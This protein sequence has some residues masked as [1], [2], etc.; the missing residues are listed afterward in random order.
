MRRHLALLFACSPLLAQ[1]LLAQTPEPSTQ[2]PQDPPSES[3][4]LT[5]QEFA[6]LHQ[7]KA[8]E[9]PK[10][11]GTMVKIAG[12]Q[13]YLALPK[14]QQAPMPAVLVIH[15]WWGLN[16]HI[17]H[18][19]D[20]L[21]A[22]GYAAL[23]VDMYRGKVGTTRDQALELMKSVDADQAKATVDAAMKFLKGDPR[24]RATRRAS[25]G[26]CFG[27]GWSLQ[28]AIT[29][30]ELD[31]CVV[32]YGRMPTDQEQLARIKAPML[33]VFGSKDRGIP[34]AKV[35]AFEEAMRKA[36]KS[37]RPLMYD[38]NHAFANPSSARYDQKNAAAAWK[39]TRAFLKKHLTKPA[40]TKKKAVEK[41]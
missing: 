32:Y 2:K 35:R 24:I 29:Q 9:A 33:G 37:F 25:L 16:D 22:E 6:A 14:N 20:R 1:T 27:G 38:A 26:W 21:A 34:P 18:W 17:K 40:T 11:T 4:E 7:L 12:Q 8:S 36:K 41:K 28:T 3:H 31:A 5:E 19:A 30:P 23:A 10:P 13:H 39:E 15:E